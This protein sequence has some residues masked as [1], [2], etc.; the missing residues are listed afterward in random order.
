M[1][2]SRLPLRPLRP[3]HTHY[4][5]YTPHRCTGPM[6]RL[7]PHAAPL[8]TATRHRNAGRRLQRER[9]PPKPRRVWPTVPSRPTATRSGARASTWFNR[10]QRKYIEEKFYNLDLSYSIVCITKLWINWFL[11]NYYYEYKYLEEFIIF[12]KNSSYFWG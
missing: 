10:I 4:T 1:P 2:T 8:A 3:R 9:P 12:L 6:S 5:V 11:K 7:H